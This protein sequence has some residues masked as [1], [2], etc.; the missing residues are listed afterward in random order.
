LLRPGRISKIFLHILLQIIAIA[1]SL[2]QHGVILIKNKF[3]TSILSG[4]A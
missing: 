2:S 1:S 3:S 4:Y